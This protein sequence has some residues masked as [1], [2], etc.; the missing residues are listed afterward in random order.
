MG[1]TYQ[2]KAKGTSVKA[3]FEKMYNSPSLKVLDCKVVNIKTAYI[4]M[5]SFSITGG[6]SKVFAVVALLDYANKAKFNFGYKDIHEE[7][8]PYYF[9]CP[10][11]ILA[12]LTPT[13]NENA[14]KWRAECAKRASVKI[15][16]GDVLHFEKEFSFGRYGKAKTF[17]CTDAKKNHYFAHEIGIEVKLRKAS[18]TNFTIGEK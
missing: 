1:W 12:L 10:A 15:K 14:N 5:E 6:E 17:T 18:L 16:L 8:M 11:S 3:F 4:A 9:E 2:Q 13:D 7:C